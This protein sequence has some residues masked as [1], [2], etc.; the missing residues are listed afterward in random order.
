M[1]LLTLHINDEDV[2]GLSHANRSID[3]GGADRG[4]AAGDGGAHEIEGLLEYGRDLGRNYAELDDMSELCRMDLL[5]TVD[6]FL[7]KTALS[8]FEIV[9]CNIPPK[10]FYLYCV[11]VFLL[12]V[13][14]GSS[15]GKAGDFGPKFI[16]I[17]DIYLSDCD[18]FLVAGLGDDV[19][20]RIYDKRASEGMHR[21]LD[22]YLVG[23]YHVALVF[24]RS[25]ANKR[26]PVVLA[27]VQS[28]L[29]GVENNFRASQ[30]E[31]SVNF[32]EAD[33]VANRKPHLAV[34]SVKI[35]DLVTRLDILY[36]FADTRLL[37]G[38]P[39]LCM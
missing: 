14:R 36:F 5:I 11:S 34:F 28:E 17:V 18:A 35:Y 26:F 31:N 21:R 4:Y 16:Y 20:P 39:V 10:R 3:S 8:F 32:R 23:A 38:R 27:G 1:T 25:C 22:A 29:C 2:A 33:V 37:F 9:H 6:Q 19:A 13:G 30:S 7:G 12:F 24:N 15:V